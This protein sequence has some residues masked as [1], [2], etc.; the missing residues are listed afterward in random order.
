MRETVQSMSGTTI[1]DDQAAAERAKTLSAARSLPYY[2]ATIA[3]FPLLMLLLTFVLIGTRAFQR[4]CEAGWISA[5]DRLYSTK[6]STCDILIFGDSTAA[7]GLDP[8]II[9]RRTHLATC[10]FAATAP[11]LDLFGTK[12]F[13]LFL[14]RNK[15]PRYLLLH[16]RPTSMTRH[17]PGFA[18]GEYL[19]AIVPML[20]HGYAYLALP[21]MIT[22]PTLVIDFMYYA[23]YMGPQNALF[24]LTHQGRANS[25]IE[26]ME[27]SY[28]IN[29]NPPL[30]DC[31]KPN[32]VPLT[33]ENIAWIQDLR[34]HFSPS[35]EKIIMNVSPTSDCNPLRTQWSN[36]LSGITD[37]SL[38]VYPGNSFVDDWDHPTRETAIRLSNETADQILA[39]EDHASFLPDKALNK[40]VHDAVVTK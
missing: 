22:R 25:N 38:V 3:A 10:N 12:P 21:K 18:D 37:N 32:S 13:E 14:A 23:Y 6:D 15:R 20:R 27:G 8:D 1:I 28:V 19:Q 31:P 33:A 34:Q 29:T 35:A 9:S 24:G 30:K 36:A 40:T 26:P 17:I 5:Q 2:A 16:F 39:L 4:Y 11:T 7:M